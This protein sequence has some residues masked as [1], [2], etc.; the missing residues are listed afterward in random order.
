MRNTAQ[1]AFTLLELLIVIA[2]GALLIG[3][4]ASNLG[5]LENTRFRVQSNE[6]AAALRFAFTQSV[7]RGKYM[8]MVFDLDAE[9]WWLESSEEPVFLP[10][11]KIEGGEDPNAP[12]EEELA[13]NERRKEEGLPPLPTRARFQ[14]DEV[15][16]KRTLD[17]GAVLHGAFTSSLEEPIFQGKA[18]VHFFPSGFAEP[19]MIY[20]G[21]GQE[22]VLTLTLNPLTGKVSRR[23]GQLDPDREFGTPFREEEEGR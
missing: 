10:T 15:I 1:A 12:T 13:E 14:N 18:F 5:Q 21:N 3:V 4:A 17:R 2:L 9:T 23:I 7:T 22:G 19:A 16:S 6:I 20:V 11:E 8:R